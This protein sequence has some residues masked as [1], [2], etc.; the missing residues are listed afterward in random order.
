MIPL[1]ITATVEH[2]FGTGIA[3]SPKHKRPD[4]FREP[5]AR[6][7]RSCVFVV[8]HS[9]HAATELSALG[10]HWRVLFRKGTKVPDQLALFSA[11]QPKPQGLVYQPSSFQRRKSKSLLGAHLH[12]RFRRFSSA[13]S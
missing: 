9:R 2:W 10:Q 1:P 6:R 3:I 4:H 11:D 7:S 5:M 13:P 8:K 12:C